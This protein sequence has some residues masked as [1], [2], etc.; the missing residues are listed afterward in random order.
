MKSKRKKPFAANAASVKKLTDEGWTCSVVEQ[1]IPHTFIKR[2]C[3]SFGDILC[4]S[5]TRGIMLVQA[6]GSTGGGNMAARVTKTRL[7]PRSAIWLASGGR[8]Q[9]HCHTKRANE[10]K[11]HCRIFE[12]TKQQPEGIWLA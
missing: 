9:I 4:C 11:R 7:E 2:D 10:T 5:P 12:I 3:F 1:T 6:T 8:I